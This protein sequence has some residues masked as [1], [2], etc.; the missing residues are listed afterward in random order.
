M[1]SRVNFEW[2]LNLWTS[3][4][5]HSFKCR[6]WL[7]CVHAIMMRQNTKLT[8]NNRWWAFLKAGS[9]I[10]QQCYIRVKTLTFKCEWASNRWCCNNRRNRSPLPEVCGVVYLNDLWASLAQIDGDQVVLQLLLYGGQ[11]NRAGLH[12]P[13]AQTIKEKE[14]LVLVHFHP[15]V[16]SKPRWCTTSLLQAH[17]ERTKKHCRCNSHD[18]NPWSAEVWPRYWL[19]SQ[20]G[21]SASWR[22]TFGLVIVIGNAIVQMQR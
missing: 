2:T 1:D 18:L 15:K 16:D 11:S 17:W 9:K 10:R 8:S 3:E 13:K 5:F 20:I 19:S 21:I 14:T 22:V 6:C 4:P 12:V 7:C